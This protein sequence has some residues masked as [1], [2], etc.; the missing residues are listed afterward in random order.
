MVGHIELNAEDLNHECV[1][2]VALAVRL[3]AQETSRNRH[4]RLYPGERFVPFQAG[5]F[6]DVINGLCTSPAHTDF[7]AKSRNDV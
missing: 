3:R 4:L 6:P 7:D 2:I 1:S 5:A